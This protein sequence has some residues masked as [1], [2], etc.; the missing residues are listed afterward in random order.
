MTTR[1]VIQNKLAAM[2]TVI[3]ALSQPSAPQQRV[4]SQQQDAEFI[5]WDGGALHV[6]QVVVERARPALKLEG[7]ED[8]RCAS[9]PAR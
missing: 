6:V 1:V 3:E 7:L 9:A 8:V 5:R 4:S 2:A